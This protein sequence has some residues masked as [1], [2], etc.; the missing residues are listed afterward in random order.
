MAATRGISAREI[1]SNRDGYRSHCGTDVGVGC[2]QTHRLLCHQS[3]NGQR[4]QAVVRISTSQ[5]RLQP[6]L[7]EDHR[8]RRQVLLLRSRL[9]PPKTGMAIGRPLGPRRSTGIPAKPF[10][11]FHPLRRSPSSNRI[12]PANAK[13]SCRSRLH[14]TCIRNR[15]LPPVA[16]FHCADDTMPYRHLSH[17]PCATT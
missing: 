15:S 13:S 10:S 11:V 17:L 3:S 4:Q 8:W 9:N 1:E 2:G 16:Q 5:S 14:A 6:G 12:S 7:T